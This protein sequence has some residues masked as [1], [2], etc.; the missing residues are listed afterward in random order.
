MPLNKIESLSNPRVKAL[1][2]LRDRKARKSTGLTIVEGLREISRAI[3]SG[4]NVQEFYV[5][6]K[7]LKS[8]GKS[9]VDA[10]LKSG[11]AIFDVDEKIMSKIS[12]GDKKDG[13]LVVCR[14]VAKTLESIKLS[15]KPLIVVVE[16]IEKPGNVGAILRTCDGAGVDAL[17]VTDGLTDLYN[18]NVIRASL[19]T[20]FSV[21]IVTS[22]NKKT[23]EFLKKKKVSVCATV[24]LAK[25]VYF[26]ENLSGPLAIVM[27]SEQKGLTEFW[28]KNSDIKVNVPMEGSA[29]SLNVSATTAIL[30]YEALKQRKI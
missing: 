12:Y 17:I 1:V 7:L 11:V 9:I 15:P 29:D 25:K 13:M 4:I 23:L 26:A 27:G 6:R 20:V 19:G 21:P 24:P 30:V 3:K 22:E 10:S 14:P 5:C 18:P 8:D 28:K 16:G 2:K